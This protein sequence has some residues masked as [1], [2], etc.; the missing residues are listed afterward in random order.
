MLDIGRYLRTPDTLRCSGTDGP[1]HAGWRG[2]GTGPGPAGRA[3]GESR[4]RGHSARAPSLSLPAPARLA[5]RV[6]GP[7]QTTQG[8]GP[9]GAAAPAGLNLTR[10]RGPAP[11]WPPAR[12]GDRDCRR[13]PPARVGPP[14][15]QTFI[16]SGPFYLS[17]SSLPEYCLG[18]SSY[19]WPPGPVPLR[20]LF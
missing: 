11:A 10:A 12:F 9:P 1:A 6:T 7:W 2:S 17:G 19:F 8:R 4:A 18:V 20:V 5:R 16:I 13:A 15:L 3:G 14:L